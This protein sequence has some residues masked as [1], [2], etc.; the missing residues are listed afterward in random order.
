MTLLL[1]RGAAVDLPN[2]YDTTPLHIASYYDY[3]DAA[4]LLLA[5][6][7][8]INAVTDEG[9]SAR[10]LALNKG[11]ADT[12]A[13]LK[14]IR[15]VGGWT[16]HLSKSRYQLVVTRELVACGRAQWQRA[17]FGK[18]RLLDLLLSGGRSNTRGAKRDQPRLPDELFA[19]IVRYY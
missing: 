17:F 18:E 2:V 14:R 8:D 9:E 19:I 13:W 3:V 4:R 6:G 16:R 12:A 1:D 10:D 15:L 5:R 11:H 7:A